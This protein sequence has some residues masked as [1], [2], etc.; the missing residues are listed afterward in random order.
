[1]I[2]ILFSLFFS[3]L[4]SQMRIFGFCRSDEFPKNLNF[5]NIQKFSDIPISHDQSGLIILNCRT[6]RLTVM[7][8]VI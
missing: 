6:L 1:M 3:I 5:E 2:K 4:H 7:F 8:P